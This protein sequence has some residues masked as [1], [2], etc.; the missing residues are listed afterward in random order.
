LGELTSLNGNQDYTLNDI[1]LDTGSNTFAIISQ[2]FVNKNKIPTLPLQQPISAT[3]ANSTK[4][5]PITHQTIKLKFKVI[6]TKTNSVIL[7][8]PT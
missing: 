4:T 5:S 6:D 1:L 3:L 8:E 7:N 2:D